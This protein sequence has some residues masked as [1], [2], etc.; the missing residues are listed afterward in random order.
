MTKLLLKQYADFASE[1]SAVA[2]IIWAN[3][4]ARENYI[5]SVYPGNFDFDA[6]MKAVAEDKE[7]IVTVTWNGLT[8]PGY[9]AVSVRKLLSSDTSLTEINNFCKLHSYNGPI[10]I[11]GSPEEGPLR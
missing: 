8:M 10:T 6:A 11:I 3:W 5:A 9:I 4:S 1:N 7:Y 2:L